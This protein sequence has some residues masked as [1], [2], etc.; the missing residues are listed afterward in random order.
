VQIGSYHEYELSLPTNE[1]WAFEGFADV[2]RANSQL[3]VCII[4]RPSIPRVDEFASRDD[5]PDIDPIKL[6]EKWKS[7]LTEKLGISAN[8]VIV[9]PAA[10]DEINEG[11]IDVWII[12][13]GAVLPDPYT[14][15]GKN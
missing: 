3:T 15:T 11:T 13:P 1:R 4:V 6:V 5:P 10:A 14:S 8:R 2:L 12:P 9:L 7:H